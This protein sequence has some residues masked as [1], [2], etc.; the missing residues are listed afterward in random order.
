[1][2][3]QAILFD[4]FGT[5][6][7]SF[8]SDRF[9]ECLDEMGQALGLESGDFPDSWVFETYR[10]RVAGVYGTVEANIRAI[11]ADK[12]ITVTESQIEAATE[13]RVA[14]TR[15]SLCPRSDA[16]DVL[17][18]LRSRGL[19]LAVIS[20]CSAEVPAIWNETP[21]AEYFDVTVFSC[22]IGTKKP[23]PRMYRQAFE[24]L[25]VRPE[26]C[27]YVGDGFSQELSGAKRLGIHP[28]L[29]AVPGDPATES[30][31]EEAANWS[32]TRVTSLSQVLSLV[33]E[34]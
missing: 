23:D 31:T 7:P 26:D 9:G 4:L 30:P 3:Y 2:R 34:C 11:C 27:L 15:E 25:D 28:V 13:L 1:M 20:D 6:V 19:L 18:E 24:T 10:E 8:C 12:G 21:F 14:S 29:I 32:G 33:T 17:R 22:V 16:I 5:L